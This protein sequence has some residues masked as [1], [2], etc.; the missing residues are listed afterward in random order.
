MPVNSK[1]ICFETMKR[2][3]VRVRVRVI[4]KEKQPTSA[5]LKTQNFQAHFHALSGKGLRSFKNIFLLL[6]TIVLL[7]Q[8][9]MKPLLH[10]SDCFCLHVNVMIPCYVLFVQD[11]EFSI[12][13]RFARVS[14]SKLFFGCRQIHVT[15]K[16]RVSGIFDLSHS[17]SLRYRHLLDGLI[18]GNS[19]SVKCINYTADT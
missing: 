7:L 12:T 19:R 6:Y 18:H 1:K 15:T 5:G 10:A 9:L 2:Y 3:R 17:Y 11:D 4:R 8:F 14:Q 13:N 16:V